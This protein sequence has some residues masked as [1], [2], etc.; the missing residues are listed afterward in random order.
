MKSFF[1]EIITPQKTAYTNKEAHSL[2]VNTASGQITILPDHAALFSLLTEGELIVRDSKEE[3][4]LAVGGG[5]VEVH[6]NKVTILVTRA[7]GSTEI[8]ETQAQ[9]AIERAKKLLKEK[10]AGEDFAQAAA[11]YRR[12]FIDLKVARRIGRKKTAPLSS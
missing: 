1:L 2:T 10:P 9:E 12:A 11:L 3:Y 7:V 8:N 6:Q 4:Y 5:Y